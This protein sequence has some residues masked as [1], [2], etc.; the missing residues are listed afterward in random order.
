MAKR[1]QLVETLLSEA[2]RCGF[3]GQPARKKMG[4]RYTRVSGREPVL[5]WAEGDE[6][7]AETIRAAVQKK[8]NELYPRIEKLASVLKPLCKRLAA[9]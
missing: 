3:K 8:L 7:E 2:Q 1:N 4:T 9:K 5:E 6:P